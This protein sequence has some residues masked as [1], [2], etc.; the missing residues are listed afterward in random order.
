MLTRSQTQDWAQE[1]SH[2][3]F[4]GK[5]K[6]RQG[7]AYMIALGRVNDSLYKEILSTEDDVF[8]VEDDVDLQWW[9]DKFI[10]C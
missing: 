8:Y 7:Q 10:T 5:G 2:V 4:T 1:V 3:L 9:L 6:I